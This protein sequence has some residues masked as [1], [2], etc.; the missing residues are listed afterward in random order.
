MP[1]KP[2]VET[3]QSSSLM[4]L[5]FQSTCVP[6]TY[7]V[8]FFLSFDNKVTTPDPERWKNQT[9]YTECR[10]TESAALQVRTAML[11]LPFAGHY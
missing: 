11:A 8:P 1:Q 10:Y 7:D 9:Q 6:H 2:R 3:S 5:T 4:R